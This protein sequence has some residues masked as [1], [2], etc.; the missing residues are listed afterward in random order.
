MTYYLGRAYP[1]QK[2]KMETMLSMIMMT[3]YLRDTYPDHKSRMERILREQMLCFSAKPLRSDLVFTPALFQHNH[4]WRFSPQNNRPRL[5][6]YPITCCFFALAF[7]NKWYTIS[8]I[9]Y[10]RVCSYAWIWYIRSWNRQHILAWF[11]S[12]K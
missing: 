10:S 4:L 6:M 2:S 3:Y 9:F 5:D 12:Q 8:F 1:K 11:Y 7:N